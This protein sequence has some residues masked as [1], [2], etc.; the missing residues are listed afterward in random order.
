MPGRD[1]ARA[2]AAG[3]GEVE[4]L[5]AGPLLWHA[6]VRRPAPGTRGGLSASIRLFAGSDRV[7]VELRFDKERCREPEAVLLR[8]P[9]GASAP[10]ATTVVGGVLA[11]FEAET[12][13]PPGAN[14]NWY[15]MERWTDQ[16]DGLGGL[17]LISVDAP[18][19]Q[20]GSVGT[21]PIVAGWREWI[22][23]TPGWT[24]C[25]S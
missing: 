1:P 15:V 19:V 7:E 3:G 10:G 8:V 14:R 12:E 22:S 6:V 13:Q 16:H 17:T 24:F 4:V 18:L 20:L 9:T 21:D 2:V 5:E 11:P 25:G 23:C